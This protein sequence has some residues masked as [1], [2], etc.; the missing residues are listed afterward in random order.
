MLF[1]IYRTSCLNP[2]VAFSALNSSRKL[3]MKNHVCSPFTE[4]VHPI[5]PSATY[6][7]RK[8]VFL[9]W[10]QSQLLRI[11]VTLYLRNIGLQ[12]PRRR[13]LDA[14]KITHL[15]FWSKKRRVMAGY[16]NP[17]FPYAFSPRNDRMREQTTT[18]FPHTKTEAQEICRRQYWEGV[19]ARQNIHR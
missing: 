2:M 1:S 10:K 13:T 4:I 7:L 12:N 16:Y 11:H 18:T 5:L 15:K 3:Q 14:N 9:D 6:T 8:V 19:F 17:D